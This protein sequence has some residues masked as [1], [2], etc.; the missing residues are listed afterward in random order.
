[1]FMQATITKYN[2]SHTKNKG[3]KAGG[4][5]EKKEFDRYINLIGI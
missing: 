3:M 2:G 5:F 4:K 1:M